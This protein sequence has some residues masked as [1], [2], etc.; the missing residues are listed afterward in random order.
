MNY[1]KNKLLSVAG[2]YVHFL[3]CFGFRASAFLG[4]ARYWMCQGKP[5][6][7]HEIFIHAVRRH[8]ESYMES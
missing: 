2:L 1:F 4:T 5:Q 7:L 8:E 3:R 6:A